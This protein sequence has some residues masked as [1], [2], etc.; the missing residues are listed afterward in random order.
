MRVLS[1]FLSIHCGSWYLDATSEIEIVV[2]LVIDYFFN[3]NLC[4]VA[5]VGD[6]LIVNW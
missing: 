4:E 2:A 5:V 3:L 6:N 1:N